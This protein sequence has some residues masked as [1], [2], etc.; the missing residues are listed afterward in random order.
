MTIS[1]LALAFVVSPA[2]QDTIVPP[3][4]RRPPTAAEYAN[5]FRDEETKA[6][7]LRAR[8]E[9]LRVD[10]SL[11]SYGARSYERIT[12][13]GT[14]GPLGG[15]RTLATRESVGDVTWSQGTGAFIE[16]KGQ[17]RAINT[18][19]RVPNPVGDLLVPVPWYPGMDA[20]WLP[21]SNGPTGRA[22]REEA[23]DT[24]G[25]VHPISFGSEAYY[26]FA[27]GDSVSI[28][29]GDGRRVVLREL[30][31]R[32]RAPRWNLTVGSYWFDSERA[33]LVRAVY[34][35]SVPYDVWF[36]VDNALGKGEKGPPWY[37]RALAQPLKAELQVVTLEYGLYSDRFWLPRMRRVDG[38]VQAGPAKMAV[39]IE[40]GFLYNRVNA[41]P[42]VPAIPTA[43]L[44]LRAMYDS[45]NTPWQQLWRDRRALRTASDTAAWNAR[46]ERLEKGFAVYNTRMQQQRDADCAA[47][48]V[49]YQTST[50]LGNAVTTR[51]AVP[52]DVKKLA[53][54]P[55]LSEGMLAER[56]QAYAST[57]DDATRSALGLGEQAAFAPQ[58][59]TRHVGLEYLRYNRV[60]ALSVGGALRQQLGAGWSWEANARG[61]LGDQTV[62]GEFMA[63]RANGGQQLTVSGYRRLVQADDYGFAFGPF[64][65]LQNLLSA[66]DEQYYYRAAGAE[67]VLATT[68][69]GTGAVRTESRLFAEWQ[70]GV[71]SQA[72][73]SVPWLFN[74]ANTF[75]RYV[76]DTVPYESGSVLGA[77]W[78]LQGAR[79]IDQKGWRVATALRLEGAVGTWDYVRAAADLTVNRALPGALRATLLTSGGSS[80]GTLPLH[81]GW[82]IGGWQTLRGQQGGARRGNAYWMAR[83][84]LQWARAGR[85]QPGLFFD[86]GWAG[87]RRDLGKGERVLTSVGGGIGLFGLPVRIDAARP[88]TA[89]GKWQVDLY[90][91]IRF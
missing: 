7:V 67:L 46:R 29:L 71:G 15:E 58:R 77:H 75:D 2:F 81:R 62:N 1:F 41:V 21:S 65:S 33:Q 60:E 66:Q 20:L 59:I 31:A 38:T 39:S 78:R 88:I 83:S 43:N 76:N 80:A 79:G 47:T 90:A 26:T 86:A 22:G 3:L 53:N 74:R 37:A 18:T 40:Q 73:V 69:R 10:S 85:I 25:L 35:L 82:N 19:L 50:R 44:A 17:R 45:L 24:T 28:S 14:I 16:M 11:A 61:S 5:A 63:T 36:E 30:R 12:A 49:R 68:G 57:L 42:A 72:T 70:Q 52:C 89:K 55:E 6:F 13:G 64:A 9:R 48:G 54:A 4:R 8:A 32:P 34:R 87:D 84:E 23:V 51:I 91:P 56:R 27:L